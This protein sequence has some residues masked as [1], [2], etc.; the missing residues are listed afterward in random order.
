MPIR[1]PRSVLAIATILVAACAGPAATAVPGTAAPATTVPV[2]VAPISPAPTATPV[3]T[4]NLPAVTDLVAAGAQTF[5]F[6][7]GPDFVVTANGF[8]YANGLGQGIGK[9]DAS[10]KQ[11][12]T[13]SPPGGYAGGFDV[14][15]GAVWEA[16]VDAP[17]LLRFD[18][19]TDEMRPIDVGGVM[20]DSEASIGAGE[21]A[22]W[23]MIG[24][25]ERKL[26]KIDPAT[27]KV[28][29]TYDVGTNKSAVRAGLGGVWIADPTSSTIVRF[30]PASKSVVAT[31]PVGRRPQFLAVGEGAVWVMN[32]LD[33]TISR[34][35]PATNRV[36]ATIG[37]G[38]VIEGGDI[39]VGGGF[40]W[41]HSST[42]LLFKI[43]P[44]TNR[45]VA[46]YGP[47][48]GSGGVA[49]DAD[50]VWI[51]AHDITTIWRLPLR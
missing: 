20:P 32:Q 12:M 27:N 13:W 36:A 38:E 34:I 26:A 41:V 37:V 39:A 10:G 11:V 7:P 21:G 16:T 14:G 24:G 8:L 19:A 33:G 2:T 28:V 51:T 50:A 15:F 23:M 3:P 31:I 17:G 42:T 22:V 4:L 48:S 18:L 45:I 47:A 5:R 46:R 35:D 49:A 30:D 1:R 43:D 25:L 9:I 44:A 6:G 29:G 40:V